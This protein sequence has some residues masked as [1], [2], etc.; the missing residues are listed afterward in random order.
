M[1]TISLL[2]LP[3]LQTPSR[4]SSNAKST[5]FS[6][7]IPPVTPPWR[8]RRLPV[9]SLIAVALA[10][11]TLA[12]MDVIHFISAKKESFILTGDLNAFTRLIFLVGTRACAGFLFECERV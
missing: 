9:S 1:A 4:G 3:R 8:L 10:F 5:V 2:C 7:S 6:T 12:A 11:M